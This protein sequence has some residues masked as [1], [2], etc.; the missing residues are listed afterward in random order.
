M[1]RHA[2]VNREPCVFLGVLGLVGLLT[3]FFALGHVP[4][5]S[6]RWSA[7]MPGHP[8]LPI[9]L[10]AQLHLPESVWIR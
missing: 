5:G 6:E 10:P 2:R 7:W 1:Y 9:T 3:V 4:W 8:S